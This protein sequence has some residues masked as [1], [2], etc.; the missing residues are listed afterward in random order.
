M[1]IIRAADL[2]PTPWKNGGGVTREILR[3]PA[4]G[5]HFD[6]RLSLAN[7]D[8]EGA[9]SAFEGYTRT[10]V[11]VRGHG[12]LLRFTGHGESRLTQLGDHVTFDGGWQT[13]GVPLGG[14]CV[15][16]NL[17]AAHHLQRLH[18]R[19]LTVQDR[20]VLDA[21]QSRHTLLVCLDAVLGI[22]ARDGSEV[23]LQSLDT[24]HCEP[25]DGEITCLPRN[26]TARL[27]MA[28]L[29]MA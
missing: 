10:L 12:L 15:D 4:G 9:F 11:L 27:F 22:S 17:I 8:T 26:G 21:Q 13:Y 19:C 7:I 29:F 6:W 2:V 1:W 5:A 24:A 18:T 20:L 23:V 25:S 14:S 16:L 3:A 28:Q